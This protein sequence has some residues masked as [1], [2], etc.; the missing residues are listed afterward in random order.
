MM[1]SSLGGPGVP[2]V[3]LVA[4]SDFPRLPPLARLLSHP[5]F[6]GGDSTLAL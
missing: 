6:Y 5:A 2:S 4:A 3:C 1:L